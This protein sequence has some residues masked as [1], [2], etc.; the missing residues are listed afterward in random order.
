MYM[1]A[2]LDVLLQRY[3]FGEVRV[4]LAVG[5]HVP[6]ALEVVGRIVD[7]SLGQT[8]ALFFAM[9]AE[10][11]VRLGFKEVRQIF[12]ENHGHPGQVA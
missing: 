7:S 1:R 6:E 12:A 3:K 5:D 10:E 2:D 4:Q 9:D 11:R 8:N